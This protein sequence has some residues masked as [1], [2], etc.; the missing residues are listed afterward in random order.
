MS[1]GPIR[2]TQKVNLD[3]RT[4][5]KEDKIKLGYKVH[6]LAGQKR[7]VPHVERKR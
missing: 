7:S 4:I 2:V 5:K 3:R 6:K 1:Y